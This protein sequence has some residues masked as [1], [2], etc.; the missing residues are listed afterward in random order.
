[1]DLF[2]LTWFI[3]AFSIIGLVLLIDPKSSITEINSGAVAGFFTS[4]NT[5]QQFI[6][7]FSNILIASFFILTLI[8]S[9]K[10]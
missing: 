7:N 1:M 10:T 6:F 3:V 9:V 2:E 8:L 5:G 4:P